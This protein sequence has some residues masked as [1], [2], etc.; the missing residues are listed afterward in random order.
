LTFPSV[1]TNRAVATT[2]HASALV[3]DL[4]TASHSGRKL[5]QSL[6]GLC[7]NDRARKVGHSAVDKTLADFGDLLR[8][9]PGATTQG[10]VGGCAVGSVIS[11][12]RRRRGA[13]ASESGSGARGSRSRDVG[14]RLSGEST[15][16]RRV[17]VG[18][19]A[20]RNHV[21]GHE[22]LV[23]A[24][25]TVVDGALD[26]PQHV[27]AN[28]RLLL[29]VRAGQV[30]LVAADIIVPHEGSSGLHAVGH[31]APAVL[32]AAVLVADLV[33]GEAY[34]EDMVEDSTTVDPCGLWVVGGHDV[35][36]VALS[37]GPLVRHLR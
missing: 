30:E 34:G 29:G 11:S 20:P 5:H 4:N 2:D 23:G 10:R 6:P 19:N 37:E 8:V 32:V 3:A 25:T 21:D 16:S 13:L 27:T 35:E 24:E 18:A 36:A 1:S 9:V 15:T 14:G 12:R 17:V 33:V 7:R 28:L 26:A 31:V 22:A